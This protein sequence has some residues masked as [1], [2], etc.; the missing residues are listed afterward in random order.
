MSSTEKNKIENPK[1]NDRIE[2]IT[3]D[4]TK[5]FGDKKSERVP[6]REDKIENITN[7]PKTAVNNPLTLNKRIIDD[8]EEESVEEK[9]TVRINFA[10]IG[11]FILIILVCL[12]I[13]GGIF[14][15][16]DHLKFERS[17]KVNKKETTGIVNSEKKSFISDVNGSVITDNVKTGTPVKEGELLISLENEEYKKN[18]DEAEKELRNIIVRKSFVKVN[19]SE[20]KP[21]PVTSSKVTGARTSGGYSEEVLAAEAK[22]R[23]DREAYTAGLISKVEYD[24]SVA[25]IKRAREKEKTNKVPV[26]SRETKIINTKV[27]STKFVPVEN[28]KVL[29]DPEVKL[30]VEKYK[31][32]YIEYEKLKIYAPISG[33]ITEKYINAGQKIEIGQ[34]LFKITNSDNLWVEVKLNEKEAKK[35]KSENSVKLISSVD[36][37]EY[38]GAVAEINKLDKKDSDGGE[39]FSVKII[40]NKSSIENNSLIPIGSEMKVEI[41]SKKNVD[42]AKNQEKPKDSKAEAEKMYN[43]NADAKV[44]EILETVLKK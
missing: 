12:L 6:L 19:T 21:V 28:Q 1:A 24:E 4:R 3:E 10:K 2:I 30:A 35:I 18:L 27:T 20:I 9:E 32:A 36:K 40:I 23:N 11:F 22:F 34:E 16:K 26:V 5:Y 44:Q 38:A 29:E 39:L 17:T 15:F 37:K 33:F 43:Q 31:K 14:Y 41:N 7:A 25:A 42:L 13:G 8:Y